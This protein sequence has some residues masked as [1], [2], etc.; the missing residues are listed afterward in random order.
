MCEGV[1]AHGDHCLINPNTGGIWML[2]RRLVLPSAGTITCILSAF[3]SADIQLTVLLVM[4]MLWR[5]LIQG[6]HIIDFFL[7]VT[8]LWTLVE[9]VLA[10]LKSTML[11]SSI[12]FHFF[13]TY[14]V[15]RLSSVLWHCW[16]GIRKS[17]WSVKKFEWWGAG[18]VICLDW[19]KMICVW[20]RLMPLP[21]HRL[22]LY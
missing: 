9:I 20:C 13:L 6:V 12:L 11:V 4:L 7:L 10:A 17:I 19:G 1:W 5:S 21:P 3:D 16:L 8:A 22:L 15:V 14:C 2:G 18:M